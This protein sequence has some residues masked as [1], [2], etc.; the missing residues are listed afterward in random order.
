MKRSL[1]PVL[2]TLATVF[3]SPLYLPPCKAQTQIVTTPRSSPAAS[4]SQTIGVTEVTITYSRPA[5]K[6]RKVWGGLVPY[7]MT[8]PGWGTAEAA[9]WRAG[10]NENSVICFSTD[11]TVN[12]SM[13]EKGCYAIF[14]E[15]KEG[16]GANI[17]F[18]NHTES[19][20]VY[21]FDPSETVLTIP[22]TTE[23]HSFTEWLEYEFRDLQPNSAVAALNWENRSFPFTIGVNLEE[24][25]LAELRSDLRNTG[26]F[27]HQGPLEA[28][29][30]CLQNGTNYEEA[31][32]W[33]DESI[34]MNKNFNNLSTKAAL[35]EK[36]GKTAEADKVM[37]EA[38]P[39]AGVFQLHSYGRELI[40]QGR[41]EKAVEVFQ[42]NAKKHP[43]QWPV[44]YGLAR[45]YSALGDYKRALT[46]LEKAEKQ[47]PDQLNL[48][49]IIANKEKLKKNEDIN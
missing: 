29:E 23:E 7:G 20:G 10:A 48:N 46:C 30:W 27:S 16:T 47:C 49:N 26:R 24:T 19:W 39:M 17:L 22:V 42:Y 15:V 14:I 18:S 9:P 45:G 4:V 34:A 6:G 13:L 5:V 25:V 28:A 35:L 37:E 21:F 3:C 44:D 31:L 36:M 12:G 33:I 38:M 40:A 1:T 2:F 11:V 8:S 43:G 32:G 41:K